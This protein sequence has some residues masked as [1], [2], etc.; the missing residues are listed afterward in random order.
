MQTCNTTYTLSYIHHCIIHKSIWTKSIYHLCIF[1][2][3]S[4]GC[5][6]GNHW[7][8]IGHFEFEWLTS[9]QIVLVFDTG[10]WPP[11]NCPCYIVYL[12]WNCSTWE[13]LLVKI[14]V[15]MKS[16]G[17]HFVWSTDNKLVGPVYTQHRL[18]LETALLV[19][20]QMR[21]Y[22]SN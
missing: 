1:L 20:D 15:E 5:P 8:K 12:I 18:L 14:V 2:K 16:L 21:R 11:T 22:F 6:N 7:D 17:T 13:S 9:V 3:A 4:P 19:L 10:M